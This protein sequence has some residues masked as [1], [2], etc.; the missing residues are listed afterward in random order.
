MV[1]LIFVARKCQK[2][3][4]S[5]TVHRTGTTFSFTLL[6]IKHLCTEILRC[7]VRVNV[8]SALCIYWIRRER[9]KCC[10]CYYYLNWNGVILTVTGWVGL[11]FLFPRCV[12]R[13][14]GEGRNGRAILPLRMIAPKL[15]TWSL[16]FRKLIH[17]LTLKQLVKFWATIVCR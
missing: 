16:I 10:A 13:I 3:C 15:E 1:L 6:T 4:F 9:I 17:L 2:I 5:W 14:A 12:E 11:T 8:C 7:E